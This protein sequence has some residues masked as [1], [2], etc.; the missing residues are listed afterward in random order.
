MKFKKYLK[1]EIKE[2]YGRTIELR[3]FEVMDFKED[4]T[5]FMHLSTH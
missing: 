3:S 2:L 4:K 5:E 1:T